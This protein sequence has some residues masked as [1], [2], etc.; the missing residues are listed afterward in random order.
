MTDEEL[1]QNIINNY[2]NILFKLQVDDIN[3]EQAGFISTN[4][5]SMLLS[6]LIHCVENINIFNNSQLI[7]ISNFLNKLS[8]GV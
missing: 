5:N 6:I 1:K 7:N 2:N 3:R 4:C 8:Y